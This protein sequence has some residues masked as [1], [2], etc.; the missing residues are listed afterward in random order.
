MPAG[1]GVVTESTLR[2]FAAHRSLRMPNGRTLLLWKNPNFDQEIEAW[3]AGVRGDL[4]KLR[5]ATEE[6][7]PL[8][9]WERWCTMHFWGYRILSVLR[10]H[11]DFKGANAAA[12]W[13]QEGKQAPLLVSILAV[14]A[15]EAYVFAFQWPSLQA[16]SS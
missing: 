14:A 6:D 1:L 10:Y 4:A 12:R 9:W 2:Q 13:Y 8:S 3:A 11:P 16:M 7:Y 15:V 5:G